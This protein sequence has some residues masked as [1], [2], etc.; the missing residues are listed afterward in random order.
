MSSLEEPVTFHDPC[1][2]ARHNGSVQAPRLA[3]AGAGITVTEMDRSGRTGFCC[4]A[5]G[6]RMWLEE[7]QGSRVN[8]NRVDEVAATLGPQGGTVAVGCP[9]CLTMLKDGIAETGREDQIRVLDVAE[10]VADRV[11]GR[12]PRPRA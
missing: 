5:G 6:G 11:A 7:K 8:Q 2:L 10:L 12:L 1:Y 4:G 3:L 9:F